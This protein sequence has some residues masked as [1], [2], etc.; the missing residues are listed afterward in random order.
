[1]KRGGVAPYTHLRQAKPPEYHLMT[2]NKASP[3]SDLNIVVVAVYETLSCSRVN[4]STLLEGMYGILCFRSLFTSNL[5]SNLLFVILLTLRGQK[6]DS[7]RPAIH[8]SYE[9]AL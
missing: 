7:S 6:R 9:W 5:P 2:T 8:C 3:Q 1:M 4:L